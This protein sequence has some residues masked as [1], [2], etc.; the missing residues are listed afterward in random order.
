MYSLNLQVR[1]LVKSILRKVINSQL[2]LFTIQIFFVLC[3]ALCRTLRSCYGQYSFL[4]S[5]QHF[6]SILHWAA[7]TQLTTCLA[8]LYSSLES[9]RIC[10]YVSDTLHAQ[11]CLVLPVISHSAVKSAISKSLFHESVLKFRATHTIFI[12]RTNE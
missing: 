6:F 4:Q 5:E 3:L 11:C 8:P 7:S 1:K 10:P 2:S 12:A 9:I